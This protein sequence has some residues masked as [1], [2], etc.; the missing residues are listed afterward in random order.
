MQGREQRTFIEGI[1]FRSV[2][3]F[4][5]I[6]SALASSM[7][8]VR[9]TIG[10]IMVLVLFSG[11]WIWDSFDAPMQSSLNSQIS[12]EELKQRR[13]VAIAESAT[14]FGNTA[15]PESQDWSVNQAQNHLIMTWE[16]YLFEGP[17][18]DSKRVEF[19][20]AYVLLEE[21]RP[22]GVFEASAIYAAGHWNN[23]IDGALNIDIALMWKSVVAIVWEYPQLIW[24]AGHHWFISLYGLLFMLTLCIGGGAISRIQAC[25]HAQMI[26]LSL[27]ESLRYAWSRWRVSLLA[28]IGPAMLVAIFSMFL[29]ISGFLL[30]SIP[31]LNLLG[32]VL[33]GLAL[34]IGLLIALIAIFYVATFPMLIPAVMVENCGGSES[35]QRSFAYLI[36]RTLQYFVY[37][38]MLIVVMILGYLIVKIIATLTLDLTANLFGTLA[39]N[40]SLYSAGALQENG[41]PAVG[42]VWY[43]NIAGALV[44]CWETLIHDCMIGWIFS[45]FFSTGTMLYLL[46]RNACDG[47]STRDIWQEGLIPGT[48]IPLDED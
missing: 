47:Q 21:V 20:E 16:E 31:I 4:Q 29:I 37:V 48:S 18:S 10:L 35:V 9:L 5:L 17:P 2:F 33:Y 7:Q 32:G 8:P 6:F 14:I 41:I 3:K 22:R 1:D 43:E 19:E 26:Q 45:G 44:S 36:S 40:S 28:L 25:Q 30:L 23:L 24:Q 12:D 38:I 46:M 15:P 42:L 34:L 13:I 27:E 39:L 11:G